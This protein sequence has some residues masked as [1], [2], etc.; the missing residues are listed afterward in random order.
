MTINLKLTQIIKKIISHLSGLVLVLVLISNFSYANLLNCAL[1]LDDTPSLFL[2]NPQFSLQAIHFVEDPMFKQ[3]VSKKSKH[4]KQA[5]SKLLGLYANKVSESAGEKVTLKKGYLFLGY[6][7]SNGSS[8]EFRY[9]VDQRFDEPRFVLYKIKFY[10]KNLQEY[11]ISSY[12][13]NDQLEDLAI[14]SVVLAKGNSESEASFSLLKKHDIQRVFTDNS[15]KV[16]LEDLESTGSYLSQNDLIKTLGQNSSG[17]TELDW[18]SL[19]P[20]TEIQIPLIISGDVLDVFMKKSALYQDLDRRAIRTRLED[21]SLIRLNMLGYKSY[22]STKAKKVIIAQSERGL[23]WQVPFFALIY[24]FN[25]LQKEDKGLHSITE[26]ESVSVSQDVSNL[27]IDIFNRIDSSL[28]WQHSTLYKKLNENIKLN[29][30]PSVSGLIES[31]E[32]LVNS[33]L[34][35]EK[36]KSQITFFR[37]NENF[38]LFSKVK[39]GEFI[40]KENLEATTEHLLFHFPEQESIV[41]ITR[42]YSRIDPRQMTFESHVMVTAKENPELYL[43]LIKK[44]SLEQD[45]EFAN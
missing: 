5:L 20:P 21:R 17:S 24:I 11:E 8:F 41:L 16:K 1:A 33:Y 38:T 31:S 37:V 6:K 9:V 26:I 10:K 13:L 3:P 7:L 12:P 22:L 2:L 40:N 39:S 42:S 44:I 35:K 36:D 32:R 15:S 30:S 25:P 29:L 14:N 43:G 28:V 34:Y 18:I 19:I 27:L 23:L 4:F 45:S